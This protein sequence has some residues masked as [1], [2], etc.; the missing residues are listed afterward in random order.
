MIIAGLTS[1]GKIIWMKHLLQQAET[2]IKAIPK[3]IFWFYKRW[4]TAYTELQEIIPHIKFMQG[5]AH[6][7]CDSL[8]TLY[9]YDNLMKHTTKNVDICEMYTKGSHHCNLSVIWLIQNLFHQRKG[10][11]TMNLNTQYI[12]LFKNPCDQQQTA[13]IPQGNSH[14]F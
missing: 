6:Q 7:D 13:H 12:K 10:N 2:M 14:L 8:P 5:I 9:I 4:Q 11:R 3:K 1:G